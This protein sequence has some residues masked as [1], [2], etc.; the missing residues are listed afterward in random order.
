MEIINISEHLGYFEI[1][2]DV[3]KPIIP[4]LYELRDQF[5]ESDVRSN[6]GGWQK[7]GIHNLEEL[8]EFK[9]VLINEI[10]GFIEW[11]YEQYYIPIVDGQQP[12]W[13]ISIDNIFVNIN[14]K[15]SYHLMHSH[16][17]CNY[18]GVFYLQSDPD[19]C[20]NLHLQHPFKSPW[21]G[22]MQGK[23]IKDFYTTIDPDPGSGVIFP[24][25]MLHHVGP[26]MSENDR[27]AISFNFTVHFNEHVTDLLQ[28]LEESGK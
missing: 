2:E 16:T 25:Y 24:A 19:T 1:P 20:G 15:G 14:P 8:Q 9:Q 28:E 13:A 5:P 23:T 10:D 26:N 21:M 7:N 22:E 27:I 3:W 12:K 6:F 17:G 18:S 4:I 11:I